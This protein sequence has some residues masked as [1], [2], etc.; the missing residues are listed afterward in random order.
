MKKYQN[1]S[2]FWDYKDT[3]AM[4]FLLNSNFYSISGLTM[5]FIICNKSPW[6]SKEY[7]KDAV[8]S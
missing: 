2:K 5:E 3:T 6:I 7:E 8:C 1:F 4:D